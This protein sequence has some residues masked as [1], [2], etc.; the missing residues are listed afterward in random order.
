MVQGGLHRVLGVEHHVSAW[1][2]QNNCC[3]RLRVTAE[4]ARPDPMIDSWFAYLHLYLHLLV[5]L[6]RALARALTICHRAQRHP[7]A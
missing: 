3:T 7:R 2:L 4:T 6:L 1:R 5:H